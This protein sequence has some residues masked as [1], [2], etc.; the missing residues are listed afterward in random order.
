MGDQKGTPLHAA[1]VAVHA[2]PRAFPFL[3][4]LLGVPFVRVIALVVGNRIQVMVSG[5]SD[6]VWV[7]VQPMWGSLSLALPL[8]PRYFP[9]HT[10]P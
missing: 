1:I 9:L 2:I 4:T 3:L 8:Y 6:L 7:K 5:R 10:R